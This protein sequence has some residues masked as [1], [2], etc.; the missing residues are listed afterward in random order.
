MVELIRFI[1]GVNVDVDIVSAVDSIINP[2]EALM[3]SA[4]FVL[5]VFKIFVLD[6]DIFIY[7]FISVLYS[8]ISCV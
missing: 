2:V 1:I 5:Y 8:I 6:V 7:I 3:Y 4:F